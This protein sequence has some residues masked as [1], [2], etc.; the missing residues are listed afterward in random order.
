MRGQRFTGFVLAHQEVFGLAI[1]R[2]LEL[3]KTYAGGTHEAL[4]RLTGH[5]RWQTRRR[6]TSTNWR[7]HQASRHRRT[8]FFYRAISLR[9]QTIGKLQRQATRRGEPYSLI[10][11]VNKSCIGE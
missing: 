8:F 2:P 10:F 5:T 7:I 6:V 3:V 4:K 11:A 9:G 1:C